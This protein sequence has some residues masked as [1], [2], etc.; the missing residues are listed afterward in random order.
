MKILIKKMSSFGILKAQMIVGAM[1][2]LAYC[3]DGTPVLGLPGCIMYAKATV[4]DLIMPRIA[5]GIRLTKQ[6][7]TVLGEGGL[8]LGCP[9]CTYPHCPFGR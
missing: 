8:C 2:M 3:S 4:F 6:D 7:F 1:I 9:S 5:A